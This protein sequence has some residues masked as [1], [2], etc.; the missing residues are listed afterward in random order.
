MFN[1]APLGF[2]QFEKGF[3]S[4]FF[5]TD[6]FSPQSAT[7]RADITDQGKEYVIAAELPGFAKEDIA[8]EVADNRLTISAKKNSQTEVKQENYLRRERY[9]GEVTR[10]F[11]LDRVKE[12][13]IKAEFKDGVLKITLP[14]Q[15]L[16]E[17][18]IRRIELN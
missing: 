6:C 17:N 15:E 5:G 8:V 1:L 12:D 2:N 18:K 10:S 16:A 4:D 9:L 3:L 7:F 11:L 13:E 14:K